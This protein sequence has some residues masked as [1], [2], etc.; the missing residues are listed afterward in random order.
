MNI[1]FDWFNS[2]RAYTLSEDIAMCIGMDMHGHNPYACAH[3]HAHKHTFTARVYAM[4]VCASPCVC[5]CVRL[6]VCVCLE[7]RC[8]FPCYGSPCNNSCPQHSN[9]CPPHIC[10]VTESVLLAVDLL[11]A[12]TIQRKKSGTRRRIL[13]LFA[14]NPLQNPQ[15][16]SFV[17]L[18]TATSSLLTHS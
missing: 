1:N 15:R 9:K 16:S 5:V 7:M 3:R 12:C 10:Q 6:S 14:R 2:I 18:A 11:H 13:K 4:C 8:L 17:E